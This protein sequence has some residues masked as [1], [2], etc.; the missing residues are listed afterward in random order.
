[1]N[2]DRL[3]EKFSQTVGVEKATE[4]VET[5]AA[6]SG[7][8]PSETYASE[9]VE[10][11]CDAI[12]RR[13]DDNLELVAR[14]IRIHEHA[15][16]RFEA[17]L[18]SISDPVVVV[19]FQDGD[20]VVTTMNPAFQ[21]TFGY[22]TSATDRPLS[23]L[24]VPQDA[25]VD[26]ID[27]WRSADDEGAEIRRTTADGETRNFLFRSVV[28]TRENGRTEGYGIY[29]DI[30]ERE[31]RERMLEHQN[32]QLE[33][34][35]SVV[36]HDLRNPLNVASGHLDA[37]ASVAEAPVVAEHLDVVD[38][39]LGRMG[40]LIDDLLTLARDGRTVDD[41]ATVHL[42]TVVEETWTHVETA[43]ANLDLQLD[44]LRIR[45]DESRLRQ[46]FENLVRNAVEHGAG[47]GD[48]APSRDGG[49]SG[50]GRPSVTV[51]VGELERDDVQGFYVAD[52]GPGLPEADRDRIFEHGYS[53]AS[54]G[55]GFGLAIVE[56]I[57]E[58][59]GWSVDA[60]DA[61]TGG[62][63]FEFSGVDVRR[64]GE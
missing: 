22:D 47:H 31:R 26:G 42:G 24:I 59:H 36:S 54:A 57:A 55:T 7:V 52:D 1:M 50:E 14:E 63:R 2:H 43:G 18:D 46:L 9:E 41:P 8:G 37:A 51:R 39:Q 56:A 13:H 3:V 30:T 32:E 62:A 58:A 29:T 20:P 61:T 23:E 35:A 27:H 38:E 19:R 40:S 21:R 49:P 15:Q 60:T 28:V 44:G 64:A 34:F 6:A 11:I 10:E 48:G 45:A 53:T 17:L 25:A 12:A 5:G 33:Q 4:L 16:R